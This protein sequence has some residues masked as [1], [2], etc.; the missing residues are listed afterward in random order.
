MSRVQ[1]NEAEMRS[2]NTVIVG[3]IGLAI[4]STPVG[5]II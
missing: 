5:T 1:R 3:E 2:S 4:V